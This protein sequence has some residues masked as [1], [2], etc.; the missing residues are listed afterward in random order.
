[1]SRKP[2]IKELKNTRLASGYGGWIYCDQCGENIG[3]LCY[4]TYDNFKLFYQCKCGGQGQMQIAFGDIENAKA[5]DNQLIPI[6]NRLCCPSD[7]SPLFTIL[8][9]KFMSYR[10][11]IDCVSCKTKYLEEK[12]L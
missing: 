6:K 7:Q 5:S 3:Y 12:I 2:I 9:K 4:V 8:D 10:Y 1:M 11:E